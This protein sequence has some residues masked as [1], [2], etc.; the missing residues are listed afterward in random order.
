MSS[1]PADGVV[2]ELLAVEVRR[3]LAQRACE[4]LEAAEGEEEEKERRAAEKKAEKEAAE[5]LKQEEREKERMARKNARVAT[6]PVGAGTHNAKK[7]CLGAN[8]YATATVRSS[9]SK[10]RQQQQVALGTRGGA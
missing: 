3:L 8:R 7:A 4:L 9:S 6:G 2:V 10:I 1:Q 5:L